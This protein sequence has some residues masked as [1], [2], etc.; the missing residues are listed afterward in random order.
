MRYS[1]FNLLRFEGWICPPQRRER[2]PTKPFFFWIVPGLL[3]FE[4]GKKVKGQGI[5]FFFDRFDPRER[6]RIDFL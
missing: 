4:L 1:G 2:G 6:G 5:V 3:I